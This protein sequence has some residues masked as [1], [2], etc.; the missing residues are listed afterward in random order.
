MR[1]FKIL[2][3]ILGLILLYN[4]LACDFL[5]L[6]RSDTTAHPEQLEIRSYGVKRSNTSTTDLIVIMTPR[7]SKSFIER[8]KRIDENFSDNHTTAILILHDSSPSL[9]TIN[10]LIN[11]CQRQLFFTDITQI[12]NWFPKG[13]DPCRTPST[14]RYRGKWNYHLMIR[15]WFKLLFEFTPLQ[16]YD[17]VMRL[18]DDSQM[19]DRWFNVFD[20]MRKKNAVY[21]A[22]DLDV[23]IETQ[24]P[25]TMKLKDF[26]LNYIEKLRIVPKQK[27]TLEYGFGN[28][29]LRSYFNNFEVVQLKF[30][31][32]ISVRQW[33]DAVDRS[34][35]I[36][37]YRWGDAVLRYIT[38]SIFA[39]AEQVLHRPMYNLSYCH[40][41]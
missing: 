8:L 34:H 4:R 36:F 1:F 32:Q 28:T 29:Y 20:E 16:S 35:G 24:L 2:L 12:F 21:F 11:S 23:D 18:D 38:V 6:F 14:Y 19:Q 13:F 37:L 10:T 41:C 5:D 9:K 25:G 27:E 3:G 31:R 30:F 22:N 33:T 7:L 17:Y 26:T 15:F 39:N 40:K